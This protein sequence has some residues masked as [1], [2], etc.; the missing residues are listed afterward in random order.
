MK[1]E[2]KSKRSGTGGAAGLAFIII[3][4]VACVVLILLFTFDTTIKF[5]PAPNMSVSV[6][7]SAGSAIISRVT[8]LYENC[9]GSPIIIVAGVALV[10]FIVLFFMDKKKQ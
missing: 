4:A 10:V 3:A 7:T 2:T 5:P 8:E 6:T 1:K 9:S